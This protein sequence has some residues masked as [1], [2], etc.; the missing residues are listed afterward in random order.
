[1][2]RPVHFNVVMPGLDPGIH[3]VTL[4]IIATATEWMPWSSHGMTIDAIGTLSPSSL[5]P[6][7]SAPPAF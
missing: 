3:A 6:C 7:P 1:M 4:V 5:S 2:R